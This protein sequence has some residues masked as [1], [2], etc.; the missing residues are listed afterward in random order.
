M[1]HTQRILLT[2]LVVLAALVIAHRLDQAQFGRSN[3][4]MVYMLAVVIVA[5]VL[6]LWP[7]IL[8]AA[9]GMPLFHI[10]DVPPYFSLNER[11]LEHTFSLGVML[12][13][14]FTVSSLA[15][16]LRMQA[17]ESET[18]A[19]QSAALYALAAELAG[20]QD[21]GDVMRVTSLHVARAFDVQVDAE[22][23]MSEGL[24]YMARCVPDSAGDKHLQ[25]MLR[26][27]AQ[28][29]ERADLRERVRMSELRVQQESL[30]S[31]ILGAVSHDLRTPLAS[32]IGASSSLIDNG[33]TFAP[34][35]RERLGAV[36]YEEALQ[37]KRLVENL[38]DFARLRSG[39]VDANNEW[40]A[41]EE[42]VGSALAA[43]RRRTRDHRLVVAVPP[44]LPLVR[45]NAVLIERVLTNLV[46]NAVKF[47]PRGA[48]ITLRAQ[49]AGGALCV[50]VTDEGAGVDASLRERI[51]E[52]F[53]R[54][55]GKEGAG[56][57]LAICQG[58]VDAHGGSIRVDAADSGGACFTFCL[59]LDS[60]APLLPAPETQERTN[61]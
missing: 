45:C 27:A 29:L 43:I 19:V 44:D 38:L 22:R 33:A 52:P 35:A 11:E 26:L 14:A 40:Q 25:A 4:V 21:R 53:F 15:G 30:R 9:L 41:I 51:F 54:S 37:M 10:F 47:S 24:S 56:L 20:D 31:S 60:D 39:G 58:I 61:A 23:A 12:V 8:T 55:G 32:I 48:S 5:A 36:I 2:A 7:S 1:V 59:P 13:T 46:E 16:R 50:S 18:R 49:V 28:A 42:I 3:V 17:R 34:E 57:G 6:G